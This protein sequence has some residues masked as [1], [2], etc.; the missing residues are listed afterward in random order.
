[1]PAVKDAASDKITMTASFSEQR[2]PKISSAQ[3]VAF[4]EF[5]FLTA[6]PK[7]LV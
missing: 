5:E 6:T 4:L 2:K 7:L 3:F 1:V